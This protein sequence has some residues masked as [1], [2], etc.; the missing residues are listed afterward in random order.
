MTI[1]PSRIL[2]S[3]PAVVALEQIAETRTQLEYR[4][5]TISDELQSLPR[6]SM[7]LVPDSVRATPQY[8]SLKNQYDQL[9]QKLRQINAQLTT[10]QKRRLSKMKRQAPSSHA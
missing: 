8:K 5:K 4:M 3:Q 9:F 7:G 2:P 6:T 10:D 1:S